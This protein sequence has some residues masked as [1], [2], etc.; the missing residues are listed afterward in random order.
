MSKSF[1]I[2]IVVVIAVLVGI[3]AFTSNGTKSSNGNLTPTQHIEG[4]GKSG[5]TLVEYGDFQCPY[6]GEYYPTV[7][8]VVAEYNEQI[9][10]QFRNFPLTSLHPNA[11]AGA[12][13]AEAAGLMGKYWQMHDLLYDQNDEYYESNEEIPGWIGVTDPEPVFIKDA[14]SLGLNGQKFQQLY[15]SDQVDNLVLADQNAGNSLGVDA[16]PTFY[17]DGKQVQVD[18]SVSAFQTII[19][20]A[21]AQKEG[22]ASSATTSAGTT[23]QTKK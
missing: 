13:A 20:S 22:K 18:D 21:I 14:V 17:L 15:S 10:F 2:V 23:Q 5:V 6:C 16:T 12:R 11:F 7:K 1:W 8:Q 19:N 4:Q 9:T 3:F